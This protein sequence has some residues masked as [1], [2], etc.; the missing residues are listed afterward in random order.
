MS[1]NFRELEYFIAI[2]EHRHFGKA[3]QAVRVSQPTLSMQFK[4]LEE[5][6]G[7]KLVERLPRDVILTARGEETLPI[8]REILR[9]AAELENRSGKKQS[10][11]RFRLGV[12]PTVSP[13]LLPKIN[14]GLS[15]G[16]EGRKITLAE[17][18]TAELVRRVRDGTID[19]A[20][21][22][23]PLDERGLEEIDIYIEPFYLAVHTGHPLTKRKRVSLNDLRNEK[24]LLLGEGHCLR[25]QAL[26]ICNLQARSDD[27][28][29]SA[30]SIETLRSMVAMGVG[31]TLIPK[32]AVRRGENVSYIPLVETSAQRRIGIIFRPSFSE[33]SL[34]DELILII[35]AA[36]QKEEMPLLHRRATGTNPR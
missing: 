8:A 34:L 18:Q 11:V 25:N 16:L 1:I 32:L 20:I 4:K 6:L 33:Q 35:E 31:L 36:A 15:R 13:Y 14:R 28:D 23:T 24:L 10:Q 29:L 22:S 21:L 27:A 3:A 26:S 19:A 9:L 7:G 30:T 12:I 5:T 2:A 17:A